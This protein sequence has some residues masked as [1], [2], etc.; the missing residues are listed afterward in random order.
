MRA[1]LPLL[2]APVVAGLSLADTWQSIDGKTITAD[3]LG[4]EGTKVILL[5]NDK[6][7]SIPLEKLHPTSRE[8]AKAFDSQYRKWVAAKLSQPLWPENRLLNAIAIAPDS[9]EGQN[10]LVSGH[11]AEIRRSS[12]LSRGAG[13]TA[14]ISLQGGTSAAVDFTSEADHKRTKIKI[15]TDRVVLVKARTLSSGTWKN[16]TPE[17]TLVETGQPI[18]I[19]ARV[20]DGK[21]IGGGIASSQEV[22]NARLEA[23]KKQGEESFEKAIKAEQLRIRLEFLEAQIKGPA[24]R[25]SVS[26]VTGYVGNVTLHHTEAEREAMRKEAEL[27]RAQIA[28]M[29]EP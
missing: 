15:D 9:A 29:A 6:E 14:Y 28:A 5:M 2:I 19:R 16:F 20:V 10:Y 25:A 7:Y 13:N 4:I 3:F 21:L 1:F 8:Y 22:T 11:V 27:I 18:V 23:A 12:S 24:G 17:K 26:G